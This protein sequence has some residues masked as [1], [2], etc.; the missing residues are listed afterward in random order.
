MAEAVYRF[1]E[2]EIKNDPSIDG[3]AIVAADCLR[4]E[5]GD[6]AAKARLL[7]ALLRTAAFQLGSSPV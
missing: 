5:S 6:P 3:P 1:V 4:N 2:H 7:S